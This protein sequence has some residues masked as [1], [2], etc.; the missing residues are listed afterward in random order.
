MKN[1]RRPGRRSRRGLLGT[2]KVNKLRWTRLMQGHIQDHFVNRMRS[3]TIPTKEQ[4]MSL[5]GM[6]HFQTVGRPKTN[7]KRCKGETLCSWERT[8]YIRQSMSMEFESGT[9]NLRLPYPREEQIPGKSME[10]T[11]VEEVAVSISTCGSKSMRCADQR[12]FLQTTRGF[13]TKDIGLMSHSLRNPLQGISHQLLWECCKPYL[14]RH[15][16]V[17]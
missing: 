4:N 11:L 1:P 3:P 10:K 5:Q 12:R 14:S 13:L 17:G 2:V 8:L 15:V 16:S 6:L 9:V 7:Q